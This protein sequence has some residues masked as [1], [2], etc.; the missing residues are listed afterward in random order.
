LTIL[1]GLLALVLAS[2]GLYGVTAYSVGH[3]TGEIGVRMALGATRS[4]VVSMVLRGAFSQVI[5]GLAIGVSVTLLSGRLLANR[6]YGI[7]PSNPFVLTA[8]IVIL[9]GSAAVAGFIPAHRAASIDPMLAL[10]SE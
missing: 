6:L 3:R 7:H 1:F 4:S 9:A 10:R 2:V 5:L 8:A